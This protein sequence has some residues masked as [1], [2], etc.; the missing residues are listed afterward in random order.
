METLDEIKEQK[1]YW[2]PVRTKRGEI[3][4]IVGPIGKTCY[5]ASFYKGDR[6]SEA[7]LQDPQGIL[8]QGSNGRTYINDSVLNE[9]FPK[10]NKGDLPLKITVG[11]MAVLLT[12]FLIYAIYRGRTSAKRVEADLNNYETTKEVN[13]SDYGESYWKISE[14]FYPQNFNRQTET[15]HLMKLNDAKSPTLH[16]NEKVKVPIY[17]K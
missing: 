7:L 15:G 9:M 17:K 3:S 16:E 14:A 12:G 6:N 2:K 10:P 11:V 1:M 5:P 4:H 8:F 13:A